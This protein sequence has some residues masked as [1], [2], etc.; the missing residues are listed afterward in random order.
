MT[1]AFSKGLGVQMG[2]VRCDKKWDS[3]VMESLPTINLN[4]TSNSAT[5]K[6]ASKYRYSRRKA[7]GQGTLGLVS[8]L[9]VGVI[10]VGCYAFYELGKAPAKKRG[11]KAV[12]GTADALPIVK[13]GT[14]AP[15]KKSPPQKAGTAKSIT[16]EQFHSVP[17]GTQRFTVEDAFGPPL[18]A[19]HDFEQVERFGSNGE[20]FGSENAN[21]FVLSYRVS[22]RPGHIALFMFQGQSTNPP[23]VDK[24]IRGQ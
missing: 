23:L 2:G 16:E 7:G 22:G 9:L 12:K 17:P 1:L 8:V 19:T 10:A 11:R 4:N 3:Q 15:K 13:A 5:S 21:T 18:E 24:E 6:R 20:I 14:K